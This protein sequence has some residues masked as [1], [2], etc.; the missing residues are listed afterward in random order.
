VLHSSGDLYFTDPPYG[1]PKRWE[2]P[3]RELDFCGVYRLSDS[4]YRRFQRLGEGE[5]WK[6][7]AAA[8]LWLTN[9]VAAPPKPV[10]HALNTNRRPK[11]DGVLSDPC[12]KTP[13]MSQ[14]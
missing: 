2:D 6:A 8:E 1:L 12:S 14:T 9:P 10:L 3:G 11:L 7:N 5:A 13:P 4:Y